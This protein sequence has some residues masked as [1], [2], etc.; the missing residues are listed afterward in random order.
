MGK[1]IFLLV[2]FISCN[3]CKRDN[4]FNFS[5]SLV[6]EWSWLITCGG[7]AGCSTPESTH[8]TMR[9]VFTADS[10][11][12]NYRNDTLSNSSRF[13]VYKLISVDGKDTANVI[14]YDSIKEI[15]SIHKDTLELSSISMNL[16]AAYKRIK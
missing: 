7:V 16:G 8:I 5:S 6:G 14:Q 4:S 15:F 10:I 3:G 9:L 13:H 2:I 1:I 12:N 11:C